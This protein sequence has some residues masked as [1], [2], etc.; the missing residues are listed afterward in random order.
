M[1]TL[2]IS[3]ATYVKTNNPI[4][5]KNIILNDN[6]IIDDITFFKYIG[7]NKDSANY[8]SENDIEI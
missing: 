4:K 6:K 8:Y 5:F 3:M 2:V 1:L 7:F